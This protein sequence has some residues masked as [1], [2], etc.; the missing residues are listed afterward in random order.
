MA[1]APTRSHI[2]MG[3]TAYL[4]QVVLPNDIDFAFHVNNGVYF[5][6]LDLGR[7]DFAI[8]TGIARAQLR[9]RVTMVSMQQS[10]TYRRSLTLGQRFVIATRLLGA[11]RR[12]VFF[13]QQVLVEGEEWG[14]AVIRMRFVRQGRGVDPDELWPL[15][16]VDRSGMPSE[17]QLPEWITAWVASARPVSLVPDHSSAGA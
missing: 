17:D 11:D 13:G 14:D 10:M 4:P 2:G 5:S 7:I 8:R 9:H 15:L 3:D 6:L 12:S 16:G 1:T